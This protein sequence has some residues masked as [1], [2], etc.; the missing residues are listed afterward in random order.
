MPLPLRR[1]AESQSFYLKQ[2]SHQQDL[3]VNPNNKSPSFRR[4][5]S[6]GLIFA[7]LE[8]SGCASAKLNQ[9]FEEGWQWDGGVEA[10]EVLHQ[11]E[12]SQA[13]EEVAAVVGVTGRGLVGQTLPGGTVWTFDTPT[14]VLPSI[15]GDGVAFSSDQHVYVLDLRTGTERFRFSAENKRLEGIG[16]DGE[17]SIFLLVDPHHSLAD[18][19]VVTDQ[20]GKVLHRAQT[21]SRLGT[22]AAQGGIGLVP[23][24][25]QYISAFQ[26]KDGKALGKIL[27]RDGIHRISTHQA[28]IFVWG[29]G[30]QHL[31][32]RLVDHPSAASLRLSPPELPGEPGWPRDGSLPRPARHQPIDILAEP[33]WEDGVGGFAYQSYAAT[34]FDLVASFDVKSNDLNWVS[35][36]SHSISGADATNQAL[37]LCLETGEIMQVSWQDGSQEL[38]GTLP[39]HLRACAVSALNRPANAVSEPLVKQ[40][41]AA[42]TLTGSDMLPLQRVILQKVAARPGSEFTQLLLDVN[43]AP[44]TSPRLRG[45]AAKFLSQRRDGAELLLAALKELPVAI[46]SPCSTPPTHGCLANDQVCEGRLSEW[47]AQCGELPALAPPLQEENTAAKNVEEK[48]EGPEEDWVE[49]EDEDEW[50]EE[51]K[52]PEKASLAST[53]SPLVK[54]SHRRLPPIGAIGQALDGMNNPHTAQALTPWLFVQALSD[55]TVF[56]MMTTIKKRGGPAQVASVLQFISLHHSLG[57]SEQMLN[58]LELASAFIDQH[59]SET[60]REK[61]ESLIDSQLTAKAVRSAL[62]T[63]LKKHPPAEPTLQESVSLPPQKNAQPGDSTE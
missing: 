25:R 45:L 63:G 17:Y 56:D 4:Q 59:G 36:F 26:L 51:P 5:L 32:Q 41:N 33:T 1:V 24:S 23:W 9:Q 3:S 14:N 35:H 30:V 22:P 7:C 52:S 54:P 18:E 62:L 8:L 21:K 20:K 44:A 53:S 57:G 47:R 11:L 37:T 55:S 10:T 49:R 15:I 31:D 34:Y 13:P 38:L 27:V 46:T 60:E 50:Q 19:L 2:L 39:S 6:C 42:L 58:A 16:S 29:R 48:N 12:G 61:L 43:R 40:V 28:D